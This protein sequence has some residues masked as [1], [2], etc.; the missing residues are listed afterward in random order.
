MLQADPKQ[1]NQ[2][3]HL[4]RWSLALTAVAGIMLCIILMLTWGEHYLITRPY[5]YQIGKAINGV[6]IYALA[7]QPDRIELRHT[8]KPLAEYPVYGINGGFFY[9]GDILS[10][11]VSNDLPVRGQQGEYGSGWYNVKYPR[12]TLIW[13]DKDGSFSVQVVS[14]ASEINVKDRERYWAQGGI[15]MNLN[16]ETLWYNVAEQEHLPFPDELRLRS[17]LVYDENDQIWLIV[18]TTRCTA[19]HFREAI[20][21]LIAPGSFKEGI[22]LDGDGS[23]QM[24]AAEITLMGDSRNLQQ[25]I[26]ITQE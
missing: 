9:R 17:G 8:D 14:S 15:S 22:F 5:T 11:A 18:T 3:F 24:N 26:A 20:Q 16:N 13:D 19:A 12:G 1:Q 21:Q 23:S 6:Q 25:I 7:T 2:R 4:N 10:L